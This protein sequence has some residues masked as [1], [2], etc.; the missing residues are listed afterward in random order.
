MV[1]KLPRT[2]PSSRLRPAGSRCASRN[3]PSPACG[4]RSAIARS[5]SRGAE[6]RD[7]CRRRGCRRS[8][9]DASTTSPSTRCASP[10]GR[11]RR[12][13]RATAT[14]ARPASRASTARI[15]GVALVGRDLDARARDHLVERAPRKLAVVRH[16]GHAEQHV[17]LGDIGVARGDEPLDQRLHLRDVLGRARL[18]AS[19]QAAERRDVLVELLVGLFRDAADRLVQRQPGRPRAARA[20][21]LSSTSVMLRT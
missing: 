2:S 6:T 18:D 7:R 5:R 12:C 1:K 3:S 11:A 4:R 16:R 9:R 13:R 20:L 8:R 10:A 14:P 17:V 21:I 15:H 19:A